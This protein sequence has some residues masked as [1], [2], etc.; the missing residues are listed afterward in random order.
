MSQTPKMTRIH[1]Q[2]IADHIKVHYTLAL[3]RAQYAEAHALEMLA[4]GFGKSLLATNPAFNCA[5]FLR[6][7]GVIAKGGY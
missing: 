4:R 7:C 3:R 1:F 6:A 5:T 2:F